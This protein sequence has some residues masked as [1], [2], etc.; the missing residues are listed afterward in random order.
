MESDFKYLIPEFLK[1]MNDI[2]QYGHEKYGEQSFQYR[3][4][5]GDTSRGDMERTQPH[6]IGRHACHHF[7]LYLDGED[8]DHFEDKIHQLAAVAFNAMM[9]AYFAGLA[10]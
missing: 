1:A 9:E 5:Q 3:R 2:G 7:G 10:R 6:E 8:H 4:L